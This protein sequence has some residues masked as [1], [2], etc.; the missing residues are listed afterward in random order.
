[1]KYI[2]TVSAIFTILGLFISGCSYKTPQ[3]EDDFKCRVD[4]ALAPQWACGYTKIED[5]LTAVGT[6]KLTVYGDIYARNEAIEDGRLKIVKQ[7]EELYKQSYSKKELNRVISE[8][9][10]DIVQLKYW[11]NPINDDIFV[12]VGVSKKN[13][14]N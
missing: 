13:F 4:G 14:K 6:A 9:G 1:M 7:I 2:T 11:Q 3:P 12:L 10:S 8:L 5:K